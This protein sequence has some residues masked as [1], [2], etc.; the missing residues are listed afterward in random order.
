MGLDLFFCY[1]WVNRADLP[2]SRASP[3]LSKKYLRTRERKIYP[4]PLGRP[5]PSFFSE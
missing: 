1:L 4:L 3:A 2:G 5:A